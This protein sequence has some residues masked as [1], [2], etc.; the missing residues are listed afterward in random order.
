MGSSTVMMCVGAGV[1]DVVQHRRQRRRL[2]RAGGAGDEDQAALFVGDPLEHRRQLQLVDGRDARRDDAHDQA[3]GAA[4]LED[5]AAEAAQ[6]RDGVGDVDLE[7]LLELVAL[8]GAQQRRGH[9][10]HVGLLETLGLGGRRE[11]AVD[12]EH[13]E[14][15]DLHVQVGSPA[16]DGSGEQVV[17]V[18][19]RSIGPGAPPAG[20]RTGVVDRVIGTSACAGG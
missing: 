11:R 7:L 2:A 10:V 6:V 17:D 16:G 12:A 14:A 18:H 9:G 20:A 5:V 15:A 4:L 3:D 19:G 1:V 8:L 13:R